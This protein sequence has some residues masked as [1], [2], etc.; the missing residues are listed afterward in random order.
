MPTPQR[1]VR[2]TNKFWRAVVQ[3]LCFIVTGKYS[4]RLEEEIEED[5]AISRYMVHAAVDPVAW[6]HIQPLGLRSRWGT[7][8]DCDEVYDF[9]A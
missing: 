8:R 7:R 3:L 9:D 6:G 2:P 1:F 5:Q 4:L